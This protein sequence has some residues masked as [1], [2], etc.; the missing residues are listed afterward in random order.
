MTLSD[1]S[2]FDSVKGA[3]EGAVM[4]VRNPISGG[5]LLDGDKPVTITLAGKDS[6]K[7]R[8]VHA[9]IL[10]RRLT[11]VGISGRVK[12]NAGELQDESMEL[13]S[14]CTLSWSGIVVDKQS[15][16]CTPANAVKVYTRFPWLREQ[17][18]EFIG[19]RSNFLGN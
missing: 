14:A 19:D 10:S 12:I 18:D 11:K 9:E 13:L 5:K 8:T 15:L 3:Q 16:E 1:L 7:F 2:E 4:E 17:V 6:D